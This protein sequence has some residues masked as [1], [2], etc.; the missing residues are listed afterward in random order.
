VILNYSEQTD[1]FTENDISIVKEYINEKDSTNV[2]KVL[3]LPYTI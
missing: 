2:I 3:D 1:E